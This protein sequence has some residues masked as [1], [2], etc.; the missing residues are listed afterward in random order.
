MGLAFGGGGGAKFGADV[1]DITTTSI[2]V[3]GTRN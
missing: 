3:T 1:H 2:D